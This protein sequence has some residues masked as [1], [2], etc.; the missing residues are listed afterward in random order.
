MPLWNSLEVSVRNRGRMAVIAQQLETTGK[1][2]MV[3]WRNSS[4]APAGHWNI[5]ER[6]SDGGKGRFLAVFRIQEGSFKIT[7]QTDW[8]NLPPSDPVALEL[9][10]LIQQRMEATKWM[11]EKREK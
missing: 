10:N 3:F 2:Y 9:E 1:Y 7:C 5:Y 11:M 6:S 8:Q 4:K